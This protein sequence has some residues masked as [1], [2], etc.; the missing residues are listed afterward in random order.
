MNLLKHGNIDGFSD[1]WRHSYPNVNEYEKAKRLLIQTLTSEQPINYE[2]SD[3]SN[4]LVHA[5]QVDMKMSQEG[6]ETRNQYF[7][8]AMRIAGYVKQD[9]KDLHTQKSQQSSELK[10]LEA[11][12]KGPLMNSLIALT[13]KGFS[14]SK[15]VDSLDRLLGLIKPTL[16]LAAF[17][18]PCK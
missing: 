14:L 6:H 7:Q 8:N 18:K 4:A 11:A 1:S 15:V 10:D 13:E 9:M 2:V 16:V 5:T 12:V 17:A 3:T